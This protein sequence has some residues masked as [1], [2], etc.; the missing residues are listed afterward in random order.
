M[1]CWLLPRSGGEAG[2]TSG[3]HWFGMVD[4]G[5][6][7]RSFLGV[8]FWFPGTAY[9]GHRPPG[10]TLTTLR[11]S[12]LWGNVS[13]RGEGKSV[14]ADTATARRKHVRSTQ[15]TQLGRPETP[16]RS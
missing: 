13:G 8:L 12:V 11:A 7:V 15:R 4:G 3:D 2:T 6:V 14:P 9:D 16:I 1:G 5:R 10:G